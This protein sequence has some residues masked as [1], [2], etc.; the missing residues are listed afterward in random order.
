MEA[1][2][3]PVATLKNG[4]AAPRSGTSTPVFARVAAE[5]AESAALLDK[6]DPEPDIRRPSSAPMSEVASTAAEVAD[7]A[8]LL[9]A[10]EVGIS[11]EARRVALTR[12]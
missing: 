3:G 6:E 8:E 2:K 5:V 4:P 10:S 7:S 12:P 1:P 9:D 11:T